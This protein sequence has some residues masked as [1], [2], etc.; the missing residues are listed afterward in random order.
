MYKGQKKIKRIC[1]STK[2]FM[3]PKS[4]IDL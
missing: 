4:Y 3:D 2:V 1:C